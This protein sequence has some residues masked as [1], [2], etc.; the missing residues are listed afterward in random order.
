MLQ[1]PPMENSEITFTGRERRISNRL[2][3]YWTQISE[4]NK[5]P[6]ESQIDPSKLVDVWD[7]CFLIKI[8]LEKQNNNFV[9]EYLGKN[10]V[11]AYGQ[12]LTGQQFSS[13]LTSGNRSVISAVMEVMRTQ[14]PVVHEMEYEYNGG[15][16]VKYRMCL[17]PLADETGFLKYILGGMRWTGAAT[18]MEIC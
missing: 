11:D 2:I 9:F 3:S 15:N 4:G 5:F 18:A 16:T 17:V 6:K 10:L 14:Q 12:D 7:N 8:Q 1:S 13:S